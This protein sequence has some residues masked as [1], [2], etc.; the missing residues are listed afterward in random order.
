[1]SKLAFISRY[2]PTAEQTEL[3]SEQGFT[4]HH[5]GDVDA[6]TVV[7]RF[8]HDVG[9]RLGLNFEGVVVVHPAAALRLAPKFLIGVFE[10][11]NRTM[12]EDP[13]R[14]AAKSL[15]IYDLRD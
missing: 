7:N 12:E 4:L 13:T 8:I 3:A 5:V 11:E 2:L 10:N 15:H 6:F 9:N 1:M 14:F